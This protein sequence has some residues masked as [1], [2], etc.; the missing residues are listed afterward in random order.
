L[1]A[2]LDMY[3][4]IVCRLVEL[5]DFRPRHDLHALLFKLLAG[6]GG[7]LGIFNRQDTIHHLDDGDL[8]AHI[9]VEAGKLDPDRAGTDD[10]QG[11]WHLLWCHRFLVAPDKIAV[12]L[13]PRKDPR[14][15]AGGEDDIFRGKRCNSLAI[16]L[17]R[18]LA[19]AQQL[20][21]AVENRD[22]VF[23]HEMLDA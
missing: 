12:R 9:A 14:A 11:F 6:K 3:R 2:S 19:L 10:K 23:L 18:Q 4:H 8:R 22:L 17:D 21:V 5:D 20:A 1:A 7:Y 15:R 13:D 16:L